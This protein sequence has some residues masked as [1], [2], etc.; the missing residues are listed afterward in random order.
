M[1]RSTL[2]VLHDYMVATNRNDLD[3]SMAFYAD[4]AVLI[5]P[6]HIHVGKA[7]I[8]ESMEGWFAWL[9]QFKGESVVEQVH[10][11]TVLFIWQG[12]SETMTLP[13]GVQTLVIRDGLI[14]LQTFW[15]QAVQR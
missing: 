7:S 4:D 10:D 9:P 2:Q 13:V 15:F 8:R 3:A 1:S 12:M 11:D 6:Q 14:V 5:N